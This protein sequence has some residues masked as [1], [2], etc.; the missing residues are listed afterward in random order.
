[1]RKKKD[2]PH[3]LVYFG[4]LI[5][6]F[7]MGM[8]LVL[9][10]YGG[11]IPILLTVVGVII[12]ILTQNIQVNLIGSTQKFAQEI[13][14]TKLGRRPY[15]FVLLICSLLIISS[16]YMSGSGDTGIG[17]LIVEKFE[18]KGIEGRTI[19]FSVYRQRYSTSYIHEPII[20]TIHGYADSKDSLYPYNIELARRNFT[21]VSVDLPGHG[22]STIPFNITEMTSMAN[23]C[24]FALNYVQENMTDASDDIY[25]VLGDGFGF[26]VASLL[27][28]YPIVPT[29]YIAVGN[30]IDTGLNGTESAPGNLLLV[31]NEQQ[32]VASVGSAI[33]SLKQF[34]GNESA[35]EGVTYGSFATNDAYRLDIARSENLFTNL[36]ST[37][38]GFT[39][40]WMIEA[41]QGSS[42]L[43]TTISPDN[44]VYTYKTTGMILG[45]FT[46]LISTIPLILI[47]QS[48]I[49]Y[50]LKP[51]RVKRTSK[52][53]SIK[54][55]IIYS[56]ILG[57]LIVAVFEFS[58][59]LVY[60]LSPGPISTMSV[61]IV[62]SIP[63]FICAAIVIGLL[64][65][66]KG[67]E[68]LVSCFNSIGIS[69]SNYRLMLLDVLRGVW[70]AS[71]GIFW[72]LGWMA[73]A[74]LPEMTRPLVTIEIM[75]FPLDYQVL[76]ILILT[77]LSIPFFVADSAWISGFIISNQEIN[78][79]FDKVKV[80]FTSFMIRLAAA[81]VLAMIITSIIS[82]IPASIMFWILSPILLYIFMSVLKLSTALISLTSVEYENTWPTI[83]FSAF[84]FAWM[85]VSNIP[86]V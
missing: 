7:G 40:T 85:V 12:A 3:H 14:E 78:T 56:S 63:L 33:Q 74:G 42:H 4:Y 46:L 71:I 10:V 67:K 45:A 39:A 24:Y 76:P 81:A 27:R 79:T 16:F 26:Q 5:A 15:Y 36:D 34:T 9:G 50:P 64:A 19:H 8:Y 44:L 30:V 32:D 65:I 47:L 20:L 13:S 41:L 80:I 38:I 6:S 77:I 11:L 54:H 29:A 51:R 61:L 83:I 86:L 1:M 22:D 59:L 43:N 31:E 21:V 23:D 35:Q 84:L 28:D 57:M 37:M 73:L 82:A 62:I 55:T 68:E 52:T 48:M 49:P 17:D 70:I 69:S 2:S 75:R 18:M 72:V 66:I 60:T 53:S 25:G 58:N